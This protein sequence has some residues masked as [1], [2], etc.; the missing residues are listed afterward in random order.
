MDQSSFKSL[1]GI[2]CANSC[3]SNSGCFY[4]I[5]TVHINN[6]EEVLELIMKSNFGPKLLVLW[7]NKRLPEKHFVNLR[8]NLSVPLWLNIDH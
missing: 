6:Y 4:E 3:C 7:F 8:E 2:E 1:K 5:P